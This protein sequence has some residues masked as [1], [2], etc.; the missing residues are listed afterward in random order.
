[1]P[2]APLRRLAALALFLA[3]CASVEVAPAPPPPAPRRPVF[4]TTGWTKPQEV[5]GGCVA[6]AFVPPLGWKPRGRVVAK[7]AVTADGLVERFEDVS[8]PPDP[9]GAVSA[10]LERAVRACEFAP[11]R[12]P[13]GRRATIWLL[14]SV[15]VVPARR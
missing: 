10:A 9:S 12:D 1:M 8:E 15:P 4:A 13:E 5:R 11:G 6:R 7:L 2:R 14:L 3:A